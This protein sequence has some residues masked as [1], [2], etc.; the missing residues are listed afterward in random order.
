[1]KYSKGAHKKLEDKFISLGYSIRY[2]KGNFHSGY[3]IVRDK[4]IIVI[5][6]FFS[7]PVRME[8]LINI[9]YNLDTQLDESE[10]FDLP[11][12]T[13]VNSTVEMA[14]AN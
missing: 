14:I 8:C 5:N 12:E 4:K 2:E 11:L 1:M 7:P 3:C 13:G 6:K 9:F 10:V